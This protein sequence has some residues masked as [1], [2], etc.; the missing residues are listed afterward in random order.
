[1][2]VDI[3]T[4]HKMFAHLSDSEFST[5][6]DLRSGY[7]HIKLNPK[8]RHKNSDFTTIFGKNQYLRMPFGLAQGPA[9]VTALM[10]K[11][12]GQFNEFCFF[13][14]NDVLVHDASEKNYLEH[15]KMIRGTGLKLKLPKYAFF[16]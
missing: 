13:H 15:L 8:M 4:I 12:F 10:Q 1:M 9:Y 2:L 3:P 14:M 11:V 6:L 16:K 7:Y 5:G